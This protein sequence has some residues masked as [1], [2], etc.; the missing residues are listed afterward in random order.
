MSIAKGEPAHHQRL[1]SR[2]NPESP[3]KHNTKIIMNTTKNTNRGADL[4][5]TTNFADLS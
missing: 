5:Q 4:N 1:P 2:G 3:F